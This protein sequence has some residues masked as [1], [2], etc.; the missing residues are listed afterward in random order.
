MANGAEAV[1]LVRV[2]ASPPV[3]EMVMFCAAEVVPRV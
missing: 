3:L 1:K 2:A